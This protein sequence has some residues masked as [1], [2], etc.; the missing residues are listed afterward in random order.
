MRSRAVSPPARS[1]RGAGTLRRGLSRRT[2]FAVL[3]HH[4][5]D[6]DATAARVEARIDE[7]TKAGAIPL[8]ESAFLQLLGLAEK[9]DT[10]RD[11]TDKQLLEQSGLDP[12]LLERLLLFDAFETATPPF[13]FRDL[14]AAR[15]YARL[16][17]EGAD[18]LELARAA[19]S[20][21]V[22]A[23]QG[24]VS[25]VRLQRAGNDVLMQ[26]GEGL[27]ELSG[28]LLLALPVD[29]PDPADRLF[30]AAR[31]AEA[32]EDWER[33]AV[34]Y[35]RCAEIEP[36]DADIAFNLSHALMKAGAWQ[37][38]RRF[39][40]K[41]LRLDPTYAEAWYNLASIAREHGDLDSAKRHLRQAISADPG[42]PDP[43]Y[44]LALLEF[45]AGDYAKATELWE[46][47]RVLDPDSAWGQKARYGLQLIAMITGAPDAEAKLA[48][49]DRRPL[50]G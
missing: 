18:W 49:V 39:L 2:K 10:S 26:S 11:L 21:R 13:G 15:Q 46:R 7:A 35:R 29:D 48:A 5:I 20:R 43:L 42:Y 34:L 19:R 45:D 22:A 31:D 38:A 33:A 28:Q 37:E 24:G 44:N 4:L 9:D 17:A 14:V 23:P 41:T 27:S 8:S 3:G 12:M 36:K 40:N 50:A 47:Y 1:R 30:E 16:S 6:G 25:N 32:D